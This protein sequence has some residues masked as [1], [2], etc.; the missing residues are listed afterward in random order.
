MSVLAGGDK[1]RFRTETAIFQP[2]PNPGSDFVVVGR[3]LDV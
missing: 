2:S 3:F 1:K